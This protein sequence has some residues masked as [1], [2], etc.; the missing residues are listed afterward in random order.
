MSDRDYSIETLAAYLRIDPADVARMAERQKLP[1]RRVGGIWRFSPAEIHHWMEARMTDSTDAELMAMET[2][3]ESSEEEAASQQR[4]VDLVPLEAIGLP[5]SARTKE[6]AI[7]G[8]VELAAQTGILWDP[9]AMAD[10]VRQREEQHSTAL[11]SG[12]ALLHPRRPLTGALSGPVI[13]IG[14]T[15]RGIPFGNPNGKLTDVFFLICSLDNRGHLRTV[16][17]LSRLMADPSF[18]DELRDCADAH[19]VR[20]LLELCEQR[21]PV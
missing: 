7:R 13:A 16:A 3:L 17:R 15:P 1:G 19:Y 8:M 6:S 18:L 20:E 12:V 21:L 10:A 5:L 9:D 4:L 11:D 2:V 14:I